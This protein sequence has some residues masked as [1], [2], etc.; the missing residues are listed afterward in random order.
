[1]PCSHRQ[2]LHL[3]HRIR[4]TDVIPTI[5]TT[6]STTTTSP[7]SA[8]VPVRGLGPA[9]GAPQKSAPGFR[10]A[11]IRACDDFLAHASPRTR[12]DNRGADAC[13]ASSQIA[14]LR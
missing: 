14:S 12:E 5:T 2:F 9:L 11:G 3:R 6:S 10:A 13:E 7:V 4:T 8:A 1:M